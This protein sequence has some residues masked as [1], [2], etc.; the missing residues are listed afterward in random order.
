MYSNIYHCLL[1]AIKIQKL[2]NNKN[3]FIKT[4]KTLCNFYQEYMMC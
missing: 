1:S 3:C 4:G 2:S